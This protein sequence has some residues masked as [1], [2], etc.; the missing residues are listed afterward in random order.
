M[1]LVLLE[2]CPARPGHA[3]QVPSNQ[4]ECTDYQR[5]LGQQVS[6]ASQISVMFNCY[7][8]NAVLHMTAELAT[9]S[10]CQ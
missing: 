1:L 3:Q 2:C 7:T 5:I 4:L 9:C 6:P 8:G 10:V